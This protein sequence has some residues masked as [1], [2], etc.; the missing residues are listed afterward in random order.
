M[1]VTF[2]FSL[3]ETVTTAFGENGIISML[4]VDDGGNCYFV[5]TKSAGTWLKESQL[6]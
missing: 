6:S 2:K 4:G 5:K 3:D 1:N